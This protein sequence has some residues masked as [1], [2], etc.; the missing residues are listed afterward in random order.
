[1]TSIYALPGIAGRAARS[2]RRIGER[3]LVRAAQLSATWRG[4]RP[5][6]GKKHPLPGELIVSL[7][8]YPA[9]FGTLHLTLGCLLDQSIKADR[10]ILWIAHDDLGQLPAAVRALERHGLEFHSCDD[11][12]SFKKLVPAL[13]AFPSAFIATADDDIY[14]PRK[15]LETLV[16]G[17]EEGVIACHRA[18]R[19]RRSPD[20]RLRPYLEWEF[21]VQDSEARK[22]SSDIMPTSGAGALYP[23]NSLDARVVD[24]NLFQR[25]VPDGDDLW[26]CWCARMAG[27]LFK[28]VGGKF[29]MVTWPGT[30]DSSLWVSNEAGGNDRMI[31]ALV[32]EF[33][34]ESL[35]L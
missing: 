14:F 2:A 32:D 34:L 31:R 1:M 5:R 18:H 12:R 8:S 29:R 20:G 28:K 6:A 13:E 27:T 23:P 30:Q 33:G 19:M 15:W 4:R 9:R 11:L 10:T 35:G 16:L 22:P 26:L 25:L 24:R 17:S 3:V 21:I 7:T